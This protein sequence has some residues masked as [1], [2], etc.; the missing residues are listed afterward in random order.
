MRGAKAVAWDRVWRDWP[1]ERGARP[2][3]RGNPQ[4]AKETM[5]FLRQQVAVESQRAEAAELALRQ[6]TLRAEALDLYSYGWSNHR[7]AEKLKI[8][9]HEARRLTR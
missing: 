6:P 8:S 2:P 9:I 3:L 5:G 7:I 1:M 4:F